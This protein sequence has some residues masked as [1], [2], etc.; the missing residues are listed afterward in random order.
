MGDVHHDEETLEQSITRKN[1]ESIEAKQ[2]ITTLTDK[3]LKSDELPGILSLSIFAGTANQLPGSIYNTPY[4]IASIRDSIIQSI[5]LSKK[6]RITR[7]LN[8]RLAVER[9]TAKRW[10]ER[11]I[12]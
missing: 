10:A 12:R 1:K 7:Y 2:L 5:L 9:I 11:N 4:E 8:N 6:D 3:L